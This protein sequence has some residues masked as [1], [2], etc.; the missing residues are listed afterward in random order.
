MQTEKCGNP[1]C[2]ACYPSY[3]QDM[4]VPPP[5]SAQQLE[6]LV[7]YACARV[8]SDVASAKFAASRGDL[9]LMSITALTEKAV[10]MARDN[11]YQAFG[12]DHN[13]NV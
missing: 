1:N 2:E 10:K 6:A 13:A 4:A 12:L 9:M 5:M 8:V 7:T 3:K 11:A